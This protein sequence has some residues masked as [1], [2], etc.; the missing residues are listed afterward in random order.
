MV[1]TL[2]QFGIFVAIALFVT[3]FIMRRSSMP[4]GENIANVL[5]RLSWIL[6]VSLLFISFWLYPGYQDDSGC[7][8]FWANG[9]YAC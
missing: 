1:D 6:G 3:Q 2:F 7:D 9:R 5:F 8:P 4:N